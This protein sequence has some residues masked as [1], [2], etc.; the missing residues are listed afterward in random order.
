MIE[1]RGQSGA[2][3]SRNVPENFFGGRD[4]STVS[5]EGE[6]A[7]R[8]ARHK[9]AVTEGFQ[10]VRRSGPGSGTFTATDKSGAT[11]DAGKY[12][13]VLQKK[14]DKWLIVRD[15]WNSDRAPV[16]PP[17]AAPAKP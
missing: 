14:D 3:H 2:P 11:A 7:P 4:I 9:F 6:D 10:D 12:I 15:T 16:A 8:S 17:A 1:R 5:R 13:T